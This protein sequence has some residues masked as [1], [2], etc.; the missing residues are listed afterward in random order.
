MGGTARRRTVPTHTPKNQLTKTWEQSP[1]TQHHNHSNN[2]QQ[3]TATQI[4]TTRV[5]Q[6]RMKKWR[7]C[8]TAWNNNGAATKQWCTVITFRNL[9]ALV[10][11]LSVLYAGVHILSCSSKLFSRILKISF[12]ILHG[13]RSKKL[14]SKVDLREKSDRL[15]EIEVG[16]RPGAVEERS[17]RGNKGGEGNVESTGN[18]EREGEGN[19][20]AHPVAGEAEKDEGEEGTRGEEKRQESRRETKE[21]QGASTARESRS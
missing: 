18:S 7:S 13:N 17:K 10:F 19:E 6:Q 15:E 5:G 4:A 12:H 14:L 21:G 1:E 3:P 20:R 16:A 8:Y 2:R 11:C 9:V